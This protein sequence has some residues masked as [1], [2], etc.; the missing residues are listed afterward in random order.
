M[1]AN[2][3]ASAERLTGPDPGQRSAALADARARSSQAALQRAEA[4]EARR[5]DQRETVRSIFERAVGANTRLS[6]ARGDG[7]G[8][9]VYRA[10]D[11]DS[12]EVVL[13]WPPV[14]FAEFVRDAVRGAGEASGGAGAVVDEEA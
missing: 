13:E 11:V 10:I 7:L 9:F 14:R 8:A 12:G 3:G 6:I 4:A 5:A 2:L 1:D